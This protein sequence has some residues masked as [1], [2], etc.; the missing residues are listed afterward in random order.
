MFPRFLGLLF[1]LAVT[2][3]M[4]YWYARSFGALS[5]AL[6]FALF[7]IFKDLWR[8]QKISN[9]LRHN[10]VQEPP[11]LGG[12]WGDL[13]D[14]LRRILNDQK[15][16]TESHQKR[17]QDFLS[18][19]QASPN[20]VVLLDPEGRI[21]WCNQTA[22]QH[23]GFDTKRDVMQH[24][25]HLVR[26]PVFKK[27]FLQE[28]HD[29]EV[30]IEGRSSS[31]AYSVKLSVQ[32]HSYGENRQ[33]LLSRDVT[34]LAQAEAMRRDFVANVSHEIRTPLTVLS[35][36]IETLQTLDLNPEDRV[37][38]L[39]LMSTQATRMQGLVN[40]LLTL[41]QLEGSPLPQLTEQFSLSDLMGSAEAE[42]KGLSVANSATGHL[43]QTLRF[44]MSQEWLLLGSRNEIYSAVTNLINNA[45]RYTP[46]DGTVTCIWAQLPDQRLQ[47]SVQDTGPGIAPEHLPRLTER[48]YRVDRSR[49]RE[50]GGTGLGL[51]ITKH[52]MQRHG[53]EL[54]IESELGKGSKF[55]LIF[56]ESRSL[57]VLKNSSDIHLEVTHSSS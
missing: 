52:V 42:A 29:G 14:R 55:S 12:L 35:G 2:A 6:G 39:D 43:T 31:L 18:A 32:L 10:T 1:W 56:P 22:A 33:L 41:S 27:Y 8:G 19:I 36:F 34:A 15:K 51:A 37:K 3:T 20:G 28:T 30:I 40:D 25:V 4:G 44:E 54:R 49:S 26:D 47:F 57:E 46:Q 17:L 23:L 48:F 7:T 45:V 5:A 21:E 9:W 13:I 11:V 16:Q 53:G 38:F 50:S 24:V